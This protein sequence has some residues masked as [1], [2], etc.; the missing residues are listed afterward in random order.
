L[1]F[2]YQWLSLISTMNEKNVEFIRDGSLT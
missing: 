1:D 2:K